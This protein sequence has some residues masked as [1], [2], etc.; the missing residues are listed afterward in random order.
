MSIVFDRAVE[1]Y[2]K[3]RTLPQDRH[4]ALI[5]A[6]IAE[7]GVKPNDSVLEIGVGTGRIALSVV[8]H[9]RRLVG[10]DLS[11]EMMAQLRRKLEQKHA[12]IELAQA[13][14]VFLPF[15]GASF[16]L[17]YAVHVY[18]LVNRWRAG[19]A[20][21][22]RV[23]KP[24]GHFVVSFHK[25][26]ENSANVRLRKQMH[27]LANELGVDTRRPGSQ[28]EEE[29]L[30]EISKW[31][32]NPKVVEASVWQDAEVPAKILEELDRQ[33]FSET[34]MIPRDK[35]DAIMPQLREWA[36]ET[37]GDLN[38]EVPSEA[39]ARWLVATRK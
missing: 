34:W 36:K 18:H 31:D 33:I 17:V 9:V 2:D 26:D 8:E 25:R 6:L 38:Q 13:D 16:D 21:A 32:P 4:D 7:T 1:Y 29:T 3:T 28:S 14:A 19:I 37:Y 10:I 27:V 35:M 23:V 24:G 11:Q 12:A 5:N 30:E 39:R 15:P 22:W 20:E